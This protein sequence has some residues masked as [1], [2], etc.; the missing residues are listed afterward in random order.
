MILF[1]KVMFLRFTSK[2]NCR[3]FCFE[4]HSDTRT[5]TRLMTRTKVEKFVTAHYITEK[6]FTLQTPDRLV[7][8]LTNALAQCSNVKISIAQTSGRHGWKYLVGT[9]TLAYYR[10][11]N[12]F[13]NNKPVIDQ[14]EKHA[15]LLQ[16][17]K[18]RCSTN[19]MVEKCDSGKHSSLLEQNK[20]VHI[21]SPMLNW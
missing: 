6:S 9:N 15:S 17:L 2:L 10:N 3:C 11:M 4:Y 1:T 14:G 18:T 13:I 21:T 16:N 5:K 7:W 19:P 12:R 8:T 20:S